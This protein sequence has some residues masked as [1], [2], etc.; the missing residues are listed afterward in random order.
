MDVNIVEKTEEN[1]PVIPDITE[2]TADT[3]AKSRKT[4]KSAHQ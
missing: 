3:M 1:A 2:L 4:S